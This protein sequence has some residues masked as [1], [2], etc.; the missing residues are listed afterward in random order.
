[1]KEKLALYAVF[2]NPDLGLKGNTS[3]VILL[4]EE[5]SDGYLLQLAEEINQPATTYLTKNDSNYNV[6]WFAP[7]A[8]IQLCGHGSAAGAAFLFDHQKET[9]PVMEST[10]QTI[11]S[12]VDQHKASI[13]L[14]TIDLTEEAEITETLKKGLGIP[15]V[16]HFRTGNKNLV[17]AESE[18]DVRAMEPDFALLRQLP[19]FGYIV[20][21]QSSEVDFVSRT[22]VPKVKQLEDPATGS[23]HAVLTTYWSQKLNKKHLKGIQLSKRGGYFECEISGDLVT[24]TGFYKKIFSG[25]VDILI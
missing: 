5:K 15:V 1:M 19:D 8:E 4:N 17:I 21:A 25:A 20:T 12:N 9:R 23:S 7:D 2:C 13:L 24:L 10:R 6:K 22:L 18:A 14:S 11:K 16:R 3:A